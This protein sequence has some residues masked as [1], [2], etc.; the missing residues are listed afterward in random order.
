MGRVV[1][2]IGCTYYWL[3]KLLDNPLSVEKYRP[4]WATVN[5]GMQSS[6]QN[7]IKFLPGVFIDILNYNVAKIEFFYR[8]AY[9]ETIKR[10]KNDRMK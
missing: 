3:I 10:F 7:N 6:M 8:E 5:R 4:V 9:R 1:A 2:I